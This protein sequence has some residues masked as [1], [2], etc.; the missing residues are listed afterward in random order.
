MRKT[1]HETQFRNQNYKHED[2]T[3]KFMTKSPLL[4]RQRRI[5]GQSSAVPNQKT[6]PKETNIF[7]S[8]K[9]YSPF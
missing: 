6:Q 8:Y 3:P 4:Y 7:K 5:A 1:K 2:L 9:P